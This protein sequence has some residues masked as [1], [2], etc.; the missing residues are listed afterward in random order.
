MRIKVHRFFVNVDMR[1]GEHNGLHKLLADNGIQKNQ[2]GPGVVVICL[3]RRGN[4]VKVV[5]NNGIL[6]QRL[7]DKQTWDWKLRR[8]QLMSLIGSAFGLTWN[9]SEQVFKKGRKEW[10]KHAEVPR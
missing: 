8:N 9:V 2:L 6:Y 7:P 1:L 5:T 4:A 10:E 3:N